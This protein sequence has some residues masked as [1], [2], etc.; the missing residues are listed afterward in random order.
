MRSHENTAGIIGAQ[1]HTRTPL[2][3]SLNWVQEKPLCPLQECT[4]SESVAHMSQA[5][6]NAGGGT[7][8]VVKARMPNADI[9]RLDRLAGLHRTS[10]SALLREAIERHLDALER[11]GAEGRGE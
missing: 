4:R 5:P 7:A 3:T 9:G 11:A 10:R 1:T 2:L 6:L 8:A